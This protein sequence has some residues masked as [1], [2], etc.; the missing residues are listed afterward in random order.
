MNRLSN[1]NETVDEL[2]NKLAVTRSQ[3]QI[4]VN[5]LQQIKFHADHYRHFYKQSDLD[6]FNEQITALKK[7][8]YVMIK[9]TDEQEVLNLILH[10]QQQT[11]L[12]EQEFVEI[13]KLIIFQQTLLSTKFIK[14]E[15][16]LENYLSAIRINVGIVQIPE[17]FL[18]FGNARNSFE[19]MRFFQSKYLSENN[20]K[21]FVMF[22]KNYDYASQGFKNL[23]RSLKE[24]RTDER[25]AVT[26]NKANE[27]LTRYHSTFVKIHN[28][29]LELKSLSQLLNNCQL[30]INE[31]AAHIA[32]AIEEK[33]KA[34]NKLTQSLVLKTQLQLL[35]AVVI[36]I[37]F[38]LLLIYIV[39]KNIISPIFKQMQH[40]ALAL[41]NERNKADIA[42]KVKSEFVANM[43]H[44]LRTPL[45]AIIGFS[46]L[47]TTMVEDK[48]QQS[49]L[50]SIQT[51]GNNLLMLLND[52]LDMSKIEAGKIDLQLSAIHLVSLVTEIKEIF[53]LKLIE[54]KL[55]FTIDYETTLPELLYLDKLRIRQILL[56]LVGN[57]IKFTDSGQ[58]KVIIK[59]KGSTLDG[60]DLYISVVDTGIGI[61]LHDQQKV[62]NSFEQQSHQ[63]SIK[64][65]GTGL[66]LSITKSLVE[67]M[68]GE[69]NLNSTPNVGSEFEVRIPNVK[70]INL[71]NGIT[72]NKDLSSKTLANEMDE[73]QLTEIMPLNFELT[74]ITEPM[75]LLS[76]LKLEIVPSLTALN[77]AF[78]ISDY[79][80]LSEQ[81]NALG[82]KHN[83]KQLSI[84]ADN[85]L[86]LSD[87]FEISGINESINRLSKLTSSLILQLE[88][89]NE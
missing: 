32:H 75:N 11:H 9:N 12:Y 50:N 13:T 38:N 36:A 61:P 48:K 80:L 10:I 54:K 2:T 40:E 14:Q 22:D 73:I 31:T 57:A 69:I 39:L 47:L 58:I 72:V 18:S 30:E 7:S 45:N 55:T 46:D 49:F 1:I 24:S 26:A 5:Q 83:I 88:A 27:E 43:S 53:S 4:I 3:S 15:M 66:G 51:A 67:L 33:Y 29:S 89:F 56:N 21:Y 81:L 84:E 87:S 64:Y 8:Q 70:V 20:E 23:S 78:I 34:H 41:K 68:G 25:I 44:E 62:F 86:N 85:I 16:L 42:N 52:V 28:A 79:K 37:L 82:N 19:L 35:A 63:S 6:L 65:G 17:V 74:N 59:T 77:K 76:S 60:L 71:T